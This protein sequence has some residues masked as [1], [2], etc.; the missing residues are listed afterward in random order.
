ML[1]Q[2]KI[3]ALINDF[4]GKFSNPGDWV[5]DAFVGTFTI[6]ESSVF[7]EKH[8]QFLECAKDRGWVEM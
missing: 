4:V 6:L 3:V 7:L 8:K 1:L 2:Q 5:L